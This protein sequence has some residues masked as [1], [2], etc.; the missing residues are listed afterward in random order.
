MSDIHKIYFDLETSDLNPVGQI[1][2]YSFKEVDDDFKIIDKC[3]GKIRI[4]KTQL[5]RVEAILANK[6]DVIQHQKDTEDKSC[7]EYNSMKRIH[8]WLKSKTEEKMT[9]LIGKN[10]YR[11]DVPY[12]R[13]SMIRNGLNPY[14]GPNLKNKDLEYALVHLYSN[15]SGFHLA[16]R[17]Y[18][19][20]NGIDFNDESYRF[21]SLENV[22]K[23]L[24]VLS[25]NQQQT[26]DASDDVDL[27]MAVAYALKTDYDF[28][29]Y[30]FHAY[31]RASEIERSKSLAI[32]ISLDKNKNFRYDLLYPYQS[33]KSQALWLNLSEAARDI[34]GE[35]NI[36]DP[37]KLF[38]WVNRNDGYLEIY[39][40]GNCDCGAQCGNDW[41]AIKDQ[42]EYL[43]KEDYI[44]DI[45]ETELRNLAMALSVKFQ[46]E[47]TLDGFF[48]YRDCDIEQHIYRMPFKGID[49]LSSAIWE[50]KLEALK[51]FNDEDSK[52]LYT[53]FFLNYYKIPETDEGIIIKDSKEDK[54]HTAFD[55][56][57]QYRY[58]PGITKNG[59]DSPV[60]KMKVNKF[61]TIHKS[62][63]DD[64]ASEEDFHPTMRQLLKD[65]LIKKDE[66]PKDH[67]DFKLL[68]ALEK[69]Y[70]ES[71]IFNKL[72]E[73]HLTG[74]THQI[75][76]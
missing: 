19:S 39:E 45:N 62:P 50:R 16:L 32:M 70:R 38:K 23:A 15:N 64:G 71:L 17:N 7:L 31:Q 1:L 49:C 25:P 46:H 3:E 11:F 10:S 66:T 48:D 47:V 51:E 35:K 53:R 43:V 76:P 6:I 26:H 2:T 9:Y 12:L 40:F 57:I 30:D 72:K 55:K 14:F 52:E 37:K 18:A 63:E 54:F 73:V 33:N 22:A 59:Y 8:S 58:G 36:D 74:H 20:N 42:F 56:Y 28:D 24:G 13:T 27:T 61:N 4:N 21:K 34:S 65:L 75:T 44:T 5:P 41:L 60:I 69:F 68:E 29:I 67:P